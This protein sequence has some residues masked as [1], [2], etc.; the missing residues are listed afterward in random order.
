MLFVES[1]EARY[2]LSAVLSETTAYEL[3]TAAAANPNLL[4]SDSLQDPLS[5]ENDEYL[6]QMDFTPQP[7][8]LVPLGGFVGPETIRVTN[9]SDNTINITDLN[10]A[11]DNFLLHQDLLPLREMGQPRDLQRLGLLNI[12]QE[13]FGRIYFYF[14]EDSEELVRRTQW[15]YVHADAGQLLDVQIKGLAQTS[16]T[17][18]NAYGQPSFEPEEPDPWFGF[19]DEEP[20]SKYDEPMIEGLPGSPEYDNDTFVTVQD[21]VTPYDG[22][23]YISVQGEPIAETGEYEIVL[24]PSSNTIEPLDLA[25]ASQSLT[26]QYGSEAFLPENVWFQINAE[27]GDQINIR[28]ADTFEEQRDV[29]II[30]AF[31]ENILPKATDDGADFDLISDAD[32]YYL[33]IWAPEFYPDATD[34]QMT[35]TSDS[36]FQLLPG[37]EQDFA[38]YFTPLYPGLDLSATLTFTTDD[39]QPDVQYTLLGDAIGGDIA[40]TDIDITN[41]EVPLHAQSGHNIHINATLENVGLGNIYDTFHVAF[42][43]STDDVFGNDDDIPLA[44]T[45][46]VTNL[47]LDQPLLLQASLHVPAHVQGIYHVLAYADPDNVIEEAFETT[48]S[49]APNLIASQPL[50]FS[51]HNTVVTYTPGDVFEQQMNFGRQVVDSSTP[52]A[53]TVHNRGDNPLTVSSMTLQLAEAFVLT[54]FDIP[55][56]DVS[57]PPIA[58]HSSRTFEVVFEPQRFVNGGAHHYQ[59]TLTI[60][61]S[62]AFAYSLDLQGQVTGADLRVFEQSG[63][64]SN[65]NLIEFRPRQINGGLGW[66]SFT[67]ANLGDQPLSINNISLVAGDISAFDLLP[68][69]DQFP[70]ILQPHGEEQDAQVVTVRFAPDQLGDLQATVAIESNDYIGDYNLSLTGQGIA[71]GLAV[72]EQQGAANDDLLEFG[73]HPTGQPASTTLQLVNEGTDDLILYDWNFANAVTNDF[74]VTPSNDRDNNTDDVILTPG[75]TFNLTVTFLAPNDGYFDDRLLIHSNDLAGTYE[76]DV[77]SL[78]GISTQPALRFRYDDHFTY[79]LDLDFGDIPLGGSLSQTFFINNNAPVPLVIDDIF[80]QGPYFALPEII[81]PT[82]D[83]ILNKGQSLPIRVTFTADANLG[84]GDYAGIISFDSNAPTDGRVFLNASLVTPDIDLSHNNLVFDPI[85]QNQSA[86]QIVD[87]TNRGSS[88]LVLSN[89]Q[90]DNDQFQLALPAPDNNG[91]LT[92]APGQTV[93]ASVTYK[94]SLYGNAF[95]TLALDSNDLDE[96]RRTINI[97]ASSIGR[98]IALVPNVNYAFQDADGDLVSVRSIN[99]DSVIYLENG[100]LSG[101]DIQLLNVSHTGRNSQIKISVNGGQTSIGKINV[102]GNLNQIQAP[103]ATLRQTLAVNGYIQKLSLDQ[104]APAASLNVATMAPKG[105]TLNINYVAPNAL[106][107]LAGDVRSFQTDQMDGSLLARNINRL[108]AQN[109]IN[110]DIHAM[111]NINTI[112]SR[113]GSINANVS[114]GRIDSQESLNAILNDPFAF[115]I[116]DVSNLPTFVEGNIRRIAARQSIA[117]TITAWGDLGTVTAGQNFSATV[118]AENVSLLRAANLDNAL[119]S[120]LDDVD[121]LLIKNN[122]SDSY[123]LAGYDIGMNALDDRTDDL[124]SNGNLGLVRFNGQLR[125][126]YF[127]AGVLT[128]AIRTSIGFP[129]AADEPVSSNVGSIG[130]VIGRNVSTIGSTQ[131][132]GL[133]AANDIN[134]NLTPAGNFVIIDDI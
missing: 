43:L 109:D 60:Q 69:W 1:L 119:I 74:T 21:F 47:L 104:M 18:Y 42:A 41:Q 131:E 45:M 67:V 81:D 70:L 121:R 77:T 50:L 22:V 58:P 101:A 110:G 4:F 85:D 96:P 115:H 62:E 94:P 63:T 102:E 129:L 107:N 71:P 16:V 132:F 17:V 57:N 120:T 19:L 72:Y 80:I 10:I 84:T 116:G 25:P 103:D 65:D 28:L 76:V 39:G 35:V 61:T 133:Y 118:R 44:T 111:L 54:D 108:T 90:L 13:E 117:G 79:N 6:F 66:S 93:S 24:Q 7:T 127:A 52:G 48:E 46:D 15:F 91:R 114:A 112:M 82:D 37:E 56:F 98:P 126:S 87:I 68:T 20:L 32:T 3:A 26:D 23:Y 78:A 34:Y 105:T 51:P 49:D 59:D 14:D 73:W 30:N 12:G 40:L 27:Y 95:A 29:Q 9:T 106:L 113:T 31:G 99:A 55:D 8:D 36:I 134:T 11:G 5:S 128:D 97:T 33:R 53:V 2:L 130:R 124:L 89:W 83:I 38:A 125:N 122:I 75:D 92:I 86:T 88:D 64:T 123:V 100:L